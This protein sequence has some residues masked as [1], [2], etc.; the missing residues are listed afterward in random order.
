MKNRTNQKERI[1]RL[2]MITDRLANRLAEVEDG[3]SQKLSCSKRQQHNV[4]GS[5][6]CF[7]HTVLPFDSSSVLMRSKNKTWNFLEAQKLEG[8]SEWRFRWFRSLILF[9]RPISRISALQRG[10]YWVSSQVAAWMLPW[11]PAGVKCLIST[12]ACSRTT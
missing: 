9:G 6:S 5:I 2:S 1:I 8:C 10:F 7:A 12:K 4:C 3:L 11:S